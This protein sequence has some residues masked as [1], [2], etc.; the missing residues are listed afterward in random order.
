MCIRSQGKVRFFSSEAN[1][2]TMAVRK[3]QNWVEKALCVDI[4]PDLLFV[5]GSAQ[6][7]VRTR[8]FQCEVRMQCL[9]EALNTENNFGVWGGLTER[10]RRALLRYFSDVEDWNEW[11]ES[12]ADPIAEEIRLPR[13]PHLMS[14]LRK[15]RQKMA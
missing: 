7:D 1:G 10:E 4:A 13:D 8:C 2:K 14:K 5:Q 3:D 11:L 15:S 6:R 12:S 9:A